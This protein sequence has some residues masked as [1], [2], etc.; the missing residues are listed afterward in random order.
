MIGHFQVLYSGEV[1][2]GADTEAVRRNLSRRLGVDERK[3]HQLFS[4]RTVVIQS[5]MQREAAYA[6]Q[7][8]LSALGAVVR[9]KDLSPDE[10][11]KFKTDKRE[12]D[13]TL[14]DITA[15]HIECPRCGTLQLEAQFCSRC[16]VDIGSANKQKRKEDL[17]IEKRIR[18]LR[19]RRLKASRAVVSRRN[20]ATSWVKHLKPGERD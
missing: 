1:V 16:G 20:G 19:G 15:A 13:F 7:A 18:D 3:A 4:G 12:T 14:R 6:L 2:E 8:E 11:A 5:Q 9:V 10:R 17:L